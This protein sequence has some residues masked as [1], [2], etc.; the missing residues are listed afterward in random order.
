VIAV[1][2]LDTTTLRCL[3][4]LHDLSHFINFIIA[5]IYYYKLLN[6]LLLLLTVT[7]SYLYE[8]DN[9]AHVNVNTQTNVIRIKCKIAKE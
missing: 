8:S 7:V 5:S 6:K 4:S 1:T 9:V 3:S 2:Y